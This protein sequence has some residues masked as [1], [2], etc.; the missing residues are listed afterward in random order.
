MN[1]GDLVRNIFTGE[2]GIIT[3]YAIDNPDEY[4][5]IISKHQGWLVPI[6]HLEVISKAG[7]CKLDI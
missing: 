6:E 7:A 3:G 1:V 4:V 5:E 2:I